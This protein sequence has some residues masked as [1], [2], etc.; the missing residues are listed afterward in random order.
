VNR[1]VI[2]CGAVMIETSA[3][4]SVLRF[5]A[6]VAAL[7]MC[8]TASTAEVARFGTIDSRALIT[9][10]GAWVSRGYG[11]IWH[12]KNRSVTEYEIA[13]PY[14]IRVQH[15]DGL[16]DSAGASVLLDREKR[17]AKIGVAD[18][19]GY[20]H[21]FDRHDALPK[22]CL[23]KPDSSP[24]GVFDSIVNIFAHRY[25]FFARR[26]VDW[27]ALA[28]RYRPRVR[29]DMPQS[30]LFEVMAELLDHLGDE[31]VGLLGNV[32]GEWRRFSARGRRLPQ[33]SGTPSGDRLPGYWSSATATR[34]L[35]SGARTNASRSIVY[36][37]INGTIG[38]LNVKSFW[39]RRL[40]DLDETL[41]RA[42]DQFGSAELVIVD[43]T[44]NGGGGED[45]GKRLAE[46]FASRRAVGLYKYAGDSPDQK[47]QAI[48]LVPSDR[49]RFLGPTYV[50]T[51]RE[52]FSAAETTAMY[53]S[54]LPNVTHIGA[55]TAG[56]LSDVL[57]RKLP[58]G[59][60]VEL[61]NEVYLDASGR[62]WEGIG[63]PPEIQLE[64]RDDR[65]SPQP[66][67]LE[68]TRHAL[69]AIKKHS[70]RAA[71]RD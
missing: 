55:R 59:W 54:S 25:A 34:F 11:I 4:L 57:S 47:P 31:H 60:R 41:D 5:L 48:H 30:E 69:D 10:D 39:W 28:R 43:I 44:R 23:D 50:V 26:G 21:V 27:Q 36:G 56:A 65:D 17:T 22:P 8:G 16:P 19:I 40:Q 2:V 58:N 68:A 9:L 38:Y 66:G 6:T 1:G 14:C 18:G 62:S 37:L 71:A 49:K 35:G 52:T 51:G 70:K 45:L 61:S 64:I 42:M 53:M 15:W 3:W 46:R 24:I 7:L 13:G 67:D 12:V 32:D 29:Q 33:P 63:I 20:L